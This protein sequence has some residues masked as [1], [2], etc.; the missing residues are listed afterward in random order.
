MRLSNGSALVLIFLSLV[1]ID[2]A[3]AQTSYNIELLSAFSGNGRVYAI[4]NS[5]LV[6]GRSS[7]GQ[8]IAWQNGIVTDLCSGAGNSRASA[9]NNQ[10]Q[11]GGSVTINGISK[12]CIW[13]NGQM[14][15]TNYGGYVSAI[16][17]NGDI[18]IT[19]SV[20]DYG[21]YN[22]YITHLGTY[23][24][25]QQIDG[26]YAH[27]MNNNGVIACSYEGGV[28]QHAATWSNGQFLD[29]MSATASHAAGINSLSQVIVTQNMSGFLWQDSVLTDLGG[30]FPYHINDSGQIVGT[31]Y[32]DPQGFSRYLALRNPNGEI[33]NLQDL[34][35]QDSG[36]ILDNAHAY[37]MNNKGQIIGMVDLAD[38]TYSAFLMTPT[39]EPATIGLLALGGLLLRKRR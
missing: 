36:L 5:G 13:Q 12:A 6:V 9:V 30:F 35:P 28:L 23:D 19:K 10:G 20:D 32:N 29:I 17:D 33:L 18:V 4:N 3:F 25:Y 24:Q 37:G 38:G 7:S 21:L 15:I 22:S 16:N 39:P 34:I 11:I 26:M 27:E 2:N 8:A 31:F 1:A 14:E